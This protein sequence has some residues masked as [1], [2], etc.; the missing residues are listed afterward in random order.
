MRE[1]INSEF[2][3]CCSW[4]PLPN[5]RSCFVLSG[6]HPVRG[7]TVV[8]C[9][10]PAEDGLAAIFTLR[11]DRGGQRGFLPGQGEG[12]HLAHM[13]QVICFLWCRASACL[14]LVLHLI[15]WLYLGGVQLRY[16][17]A[18]DR[19]RSCQTGKQAIQKWKRCFSVIGFGGVGINPCREAE[20]INVNAI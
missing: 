11:G 13:R 5:S 7:T 15:C 3:R 12:P 6:R 1:R 16:A 4:W 19:D 8:P 2:S 9:E 14:S 18:D 17:P 20:S 10:P